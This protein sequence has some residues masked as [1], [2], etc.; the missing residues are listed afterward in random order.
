MLAYHRRLFAFDHWANL[1]SLAALAPAA[2]RA[3]RSVAWL[4]HI[5][6]AKR[7]WLAR[8]TGTTPPFGVNP[9]FGVDDLRGEFASARDGWAAFLETLS[10]ADLDRV[11]RY[12]NLKGDPFETLL[13][14]IL[15]HVPVHGQHHRGQVNADLRAAGLTPPAIDYIHAAR[16]GALD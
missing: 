10:G 15:A 13:G 16:S 6:G 2:D 11:I 12:A 7:I 1:T 4:N 14:D 5:L 3:P 8:V 9:T